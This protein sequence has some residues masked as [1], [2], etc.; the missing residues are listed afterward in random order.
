MI[1]R[2]RRVLVVTPGL[3]SATG[4]GFD[5]RVFHLLRYLAREH[6]VTVACMGPIEGN[7]ASQELS[8]LVD[9]VHAIP[10]PPQGGWR[11]RAAQV[12]SVATG[13]SFEWARL[14]THGAQLALDRLLQGEVFDIVQV[15]S[16]QMGGFTLSGNAAVVLDEHNIE[17][18]LIDRMSRGE[19]SWPRRLYCRQESAKLRAAEIALW[20]RVDACAVTSSRDQ[21]TIDREAPS[22]LTSVVPNGVD[23]DE[24]PATA[25]AADGG[26]RILFTGTM[27]YRP[28]R[29]A[30]LY[31]VRDI[32]PRI[33]RRFPDASLT[34]C[35]QSPP[36]EVAALA[37]EQVMVT[38]RVPDVQ[39]Y[40]ADATVVVAP[41]RVG[42]GTRLKIL[43]AMAMSR[44][45]VT[46]TIGCE[47]ID[48][49]GGS[50]VLIADAPD[51][52]ADAVC[53]LLAEPALRQRLG[54]E[55]RR[56]V[57]GRYGWEAA[58]ARLDELHSR[59]V[60]ARA[61]A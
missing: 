59:C 24:F 52:F 6:H 16:A 19:S 51:E 34:I 61:A 22:T 58:A 25:D 15:E 12:S 38:G 42:A 11:K 28:N 40:L 37:C 29:D 32:L 46:S 48:V 21:E 54:R 60:A 36:P 45:V 35:G 2:G 49:S 41:L 17:Y 8:G 47:G 10:S 18:E 7:E 56:L 23:L 44:P 3:P 5:K 1:G 4:S 14:H 33:H 26:R 53:H 57:E 43:E 39:P 30:A 13:R 9:R 55:G 20:R 31:F 27:N 50:H